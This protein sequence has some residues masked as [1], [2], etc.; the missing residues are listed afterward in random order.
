MEE[1]EKRDKN[2][3]QLR[4]SRFER[5]EKAAAAAWE[6]GVS[7]SSSFRLLV[8][9]GGGLFAYACARKGGP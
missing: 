4:R 5:V 2:T 9:R 7:T 6:E 3:R 1:I 8:T